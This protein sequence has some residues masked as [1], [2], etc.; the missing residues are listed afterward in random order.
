MLYGSKKFQEKILDVAQYF[1]DKNNFMLIY[2]ATI[3]SVSQGINLP[4]SDYDIRFLFLEKENIGKIY[5]PW[6]TP[7]KKLHLKYQPEDIREKNLIYDGF[8][9]WEATSFFQFLKKPTYT[10]EVSLGL[11]NVVART[12]LSPYAW[13][14]YGLQIKLEPLMNSIYNVR[15]Q[16]DWYRSILL[17]YSENQNEIISWK[18]YLKAIYAALALIYISKNNKFCPIYLQ[19]LAYLTV[20]Q[21]IA[22][23]IQECIDN[24]Y[25][26][27]NESARRKLEIDRIIEN[28]MHISIKTIETT[29]N[30]CDAVLE[31]IYSIIFHS[32]K[33]FDIDTISIKPE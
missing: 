8:P 20:S 12:L 28:A 13:D 17:N 2:G 32:V 6:N 4:D 26:T 31:S 11:Y 23:L 21:N 7:E 33:R 18:K 16:F 15:W 5:V 22:C 1:A 29:E 24:A 10:G 9:F 30:S 19:T 27:W 3:G 14:P 25:S